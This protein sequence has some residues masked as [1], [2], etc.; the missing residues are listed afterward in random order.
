MVSPGQLFVL[1]YTFCQV[2]IFIA[3]GIGLDPRQ[4]K[5]L[6][7]AFAP[8]LIGLVLGL[9]NMAS[10]LA[11]PGYTGMCKSPEQ[12]LRGRWLTIG[13]IQ[14]CSMFGPDDSERR[15]AISLCPLACSSGRHD[16]QWCILPFSSALGTRGVFLPKNEW[17]LEEDA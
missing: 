12:V 13:S 14:P 5:T 6:G 17:R 7:P 9:G 8:A 11:K 2:L 4:G 3:F 1:E 10:A 15:D 16:V